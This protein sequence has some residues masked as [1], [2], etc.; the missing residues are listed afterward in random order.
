MN[1]ENSTAGLQSFLTEVSTMHKHLCPRQVLGIRAGMYA[2]E[3]LGLAL[4]QQDK[5]VLAF[6]ET[7]GCFVDGVTAASG[8]SIGHRTLRLMDYGKVAATFV[9]TKTG[10]AF[11]IWPSPQCR[12]RAADYAP[13]A[14]NRWRAQLEAYQSMPAKELLSAC[15]VELLVDLKALIAQPGGRVSCGTCGEEILNQRE[16]MLDGQVLCASCA[17]GGYARF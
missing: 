17:H 15:A 4:P 9:D 12:A 8:C 7:D 6:V 10:S 16:V 14:P 2:A 3:L 1:P 11:R 13:S 5:R